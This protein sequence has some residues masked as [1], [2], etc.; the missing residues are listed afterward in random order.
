MT[1][2]KRMKPW[3]RVQ[4]GRLAFLAAGVLI[5]SLIAGTASAASHSD[6][7]AKA[8]MRHYTVAASGFAP[9]SLGNTSEDYENQ[10]DPA[11]LSNDSDRCFNAAV[12]LPNGATIQSV[13]FFYTNGA[14]D[15][16]Y[17]ELNRQNLV[18]HRSARL[19]EFTSNPTGTSPVYSVHT[20][21]VTERRVV[22]TKQYA[23]GLGACPTGDSTFTAAR[24]NYTYAG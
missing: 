24:V 20:I 22:D 16:F 14:T 6:G 19:A 2:N 5:G 10:W 12:L 21:T 8:T 4:L 7:P 18:Q 1:T 11:T 3:K 13:T 15:S 9:D 23:Y 17:G